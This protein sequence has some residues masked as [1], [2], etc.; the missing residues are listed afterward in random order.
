MLK[1]LTIC[2]F[3]ILSLNSFSQPFL[4]KPNITLTENNHV[5]L[6]DSVNNKTISVVIN[7][8]YMNHYL[9]NKKLPMYLVVDS[10]GGDIEA[11]F[12]LIEAIK[13]LNRKIHVICMFCASMGFQILQQASGDRLV[14]DSS[15]AMS[16]KARGSFSGEFPGQL[17][18]RYY[19]YLK[20]IK[21][22]DEH[23]VA[24]TKGKQTLESY[25]KLYENEYWC[26][27]DDCIKDGFADKKVTITC[28]KS[29]LNVEIVEKS[30]FMGLISFKVTMSKC[31]LIVAPLG[32]T[33][34]DRRY[35]EFYRDQR[36]IKTVR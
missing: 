27:G 36:V 17:D 7:K 5:T 4:P 25:T 20:R 28:D 32:K 35:Y 34:Q 30:G 3:T 8:L 9:L 11:G 26:T 15:Y 2:L 14:L 31:P 10:P 16:H 1:V 29:L 12:L 6:N 21:M 13:G 18:S 33:E 19:S 23:T 24:R 22:L